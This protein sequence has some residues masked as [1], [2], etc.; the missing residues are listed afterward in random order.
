MTSTVLTQPDYY[1]G[2]PQWS[3][4]AWHD[5][6]FAGQQGLSELRGYSNCFNSV[7]GNTT[8]YGLPSPEAVARWRGES[9]E[10]FRFSFKFPGEISHKRML[11]GV[12][13][14]LL[15]FLQRLAPLE[16][17][18][19]MLWLQLPAIFSPR[20]LPALADFLRLLPAGFSYAV[21]VRHP[22]FFSAG[23]AD[24]ELTELLASAGVNRVCFDTRAL[25]RHP[26]TDPITQEAFKAKPR[27]PL[28]P[29]A[30]A[31]APMLRFISPLDRALAEQELAFWVQCVAKWIGQGRKPWLFFHTPDNAEAPL[32]A[33]R[34]VELLGNGCRGFVDW[35]EPRQVQAGLF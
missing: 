15:T 21:E 11:T 29:V 8:F 9:G 10:Q 26:S 27:L 28:R 34:F 35:P 20:D 25:F 16:H 14:L 32:L 24:R 19:G 13:Q 31:A 18:L 23:D 17:K 6:L 5:T 22:E 7:E 33:R 30:T 1:I 3:H 12:D 4:P 2:L